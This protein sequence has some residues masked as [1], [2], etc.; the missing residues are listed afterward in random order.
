M[1]PAFLD[2]V[3]RQSEAA[4]HILVTMPEDYFS[5]VSVNVNWHDRREGRD[6]STETIEDTDSSQKQ[7]RLS[8]GSHSLFRLPVT[9]QK[10][11]CAH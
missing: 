9:A 7:H 10:S 11:Y 8:N 3:R 4:I 5:Q 2:L 6:R 1:L